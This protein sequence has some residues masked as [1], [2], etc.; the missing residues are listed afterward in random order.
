MIVFLVS[1][2]EKHTRIKKD[3]HLKL[4]TTL[5]HNRRGEKKHLTSLLGRMSAQKDKIAQ[6][7]SLYW[8]PH[9]T[10]LKPAV[11]LFS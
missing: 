5:S 6:A 1:C 7:L 8:T 4:Y 3:A 11:Q 9:Q 10:C 2:S